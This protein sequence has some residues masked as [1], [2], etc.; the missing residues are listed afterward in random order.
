L[1]LDLQKYDTATH[2]QRI[3][4]STACRYP[5]T[6]ALAKAAQ[7]SSTHTAWQHHAQAG[8]GN[9]HRCYGATGQAALVG[10]VLAGPSRCEAMRHPLPHTQWLRHHHMSAQSHAA[11]ARMPPALICRYTLQAEHSPAA[12]LL[13]AVASTHGLDQRDPCNKSST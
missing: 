2:G 9:T 7:H 4:C 11:P 6:T 13:Q 12:G 5:C 3:Q 1:H 10:D 8:G